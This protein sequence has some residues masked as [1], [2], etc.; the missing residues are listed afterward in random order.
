MRLPLSSEV[1]SSQPTVKVV[2]P[3]PVIRRFRPA[4]NTRASTQPLTVNGR[5]SRSNRPSQSGPPIPIVNPV[6]ELNEN[7]SCP[8]CAIDVANDQRGLVC[9]MCKS[10]YHADCLYMT[11][12]DYL[13]LSVSPDDWF[14]DHC[15]SV[16]ASRIKWD[17]LEGEVS[18]L[19]A[20]K[21]AYKEVTSWR[22]NIFSLPRG[23]C[24][25]DFLK[26]LTRLI[27]LFVDR[28]YWERLSLPL[29]H[30]FI[31]IMLQK[32]GPKSKAKDH[33]KYLAARLG[34]WSRGELSS[35][36]EEAR[37]IQARLVKRKFAGDESKRKAFCRLMLMGKVGQAA[38][39]I[40]NGDCISGVHKITEEVKK[41]L[42]LKHPKAEEMHPEAL[43]NITKPTPNPVIYEQITPEIIQKSS[44]ELKGSGGPTLVDADMWKHFLCSRAYGK[45]PYHLAEAIAGLAKRVCSEQIHPEFLSEFTSC[46]LVPLD[47]GPDKNGMPG[48]R[49]IGIGEVL[50]RIVG[51]SVMLV[52]KPDIQVAGGCLQT[53]T[54]TRSGI[55]AA[56]HAAATTW[57]DPN[58]EALLQVDAENAFNK[59]NRKVALHNIKEICP[60]I[61]M[62]LFNHY[63]KPANLTVSDGSQQEHFLSEEGCT[64]GDPAAMIFYALGVKPL[65]DALDS[66]ND[67]GLQQSWHADD[68][69]ALGKLKKIRCWW[70]LLSTLGPKFGYFPKPSKTVIV[71][72]SEALL[73]EAK[74]VFANT[75]ITITTVGQ[76][77]LGAAIGDK[78]FKKSYVEK[79]VTEWVRDVEELAE[80]ALEEPQFA[81]SAYTKCICHRWT[82]VQRTIPDTEDLFSPLEDCLRSKLIPALV[83]RQV[84]DLER[85]FLSLPVRYGGLGMADPCE[86]ANREYAAS[87]RVTQN[88]TS[89]I[90]QQE[91]D[92][93]YYDL[94]LTSN[95]IKSLVKEKE[96]F[97]ENKF[98]SILDQIG[99]ENKNLK[100]CLQLNREKGVGSWLTVLP[101]KDQKWSLNKQEFRDAI[102]L[103][104]GWK[105]PNTPQHCGCGAKNGINH[106]LIC[107][108]GGYVAMRH[109]A[110]RDLH[111]ELQQ[112]ACRDV[113]VEPQLLPLTEQSEVSG[114]SGDRAAP[115]VSSR[116]LWGP[117]ERTFFDVRVL[118]PNAPSYISTN[119]STLY[120]N[121]EK[122]KMRKYNSRIITVEK[123]TFTPLVY[124]TFGGCGPQAAAYHKRLAQLI[125]TKRNE[126]YHHVINNIRTRI[127]FCLLRSVLVSLRGERG[128][129][130]RN[131]IPLQ[132]VAFN[133]V[134]D[135]MSYE[136]F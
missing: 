121:H 84:S 83:G 56:I 94:E 88:L 2:Q 13:I 98:K 118:H 6:T 74:S 78:A 65:V 71:L 15:L 38:K 41:S 69:S 100:R 110:L 46:R 59:L 31:P 5:G 79:K 86:N 35:L 128:K 50:R 82:Y 52:F 32:P 103:R 125:S 49:P 92:F 73:D 26:E 108:K 4:R 106:T 8:I 51:K 17:L 36:L 19:N 25:S 130:Q 61:H 99:D 136:C 23:K 105:I 120:A 60:P 109:N 24:G 33:A 54:G 112:E 90:I 48:I 47:K 37:E 40:N 75:G 44:R 107:A 126:A 129:K 27:Y 16:R 87:K 124:S 29:I 111:A 117:F 127:R 134:P 116:G 119:T 91:Q 7:V 68:S 28:T 135:A 133:L 131:A 12:N 57:E 122:E 58:T 76:R 20:V 93:H 64:Q 10:W 113:V 53:C 3:S 101:L 132:S 9:D 85:S 55:E 80:I 21:G 96:D 123:A 67:K 18:I 97:I 30:I 45:L 95:T 63:Q 43:L 39:Y 70:Q 115:D 114:V 34:K 66:A 42:L 77:H 72:K 102:C 62:F 11:E 1:S 22:K 89:L 104:Y 14:C 81:L